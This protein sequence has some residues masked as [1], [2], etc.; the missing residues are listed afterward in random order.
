MD[1]MVLVVL[2]ANV[3][4]VFV[5]VLLLG[6]AISFLLSFLCDW[7]SYWLLG[8]AMRSYSCAACAPT[9]SG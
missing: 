9:A 6:W 2:V 1:F 3:A 4:V 8:C 7:G 5:T